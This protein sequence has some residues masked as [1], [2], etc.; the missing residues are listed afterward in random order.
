MVLWYYNTF[1]ISTGT[2]EQGKGTVSALEVN[3]LAF[4]LNR[5]ENLVEGCLLASRKD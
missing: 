5:F 4:N 1:M 2:K 3:L